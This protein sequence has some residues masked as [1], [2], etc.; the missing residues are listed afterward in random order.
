MIYVLSYPTFKE[1]LGRIESHKLN[2]FDAQDMC[3]IC[4]NDTIVP[5]FE[6]DHP[7]FKTDF[8][9]VLQL[10][11]DDVTEDC[12]VPIMGRDTTHTVKAMTTEQ[13]YNIINF[14][15][16][17]IEIGK[18]KNVLIHCR[19][20]ISRSGAVGS[21]LTNLLNIPYT[22]FKR[23]NPQILPNPHVLSTLN[24]LYRSNNFNN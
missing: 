4:I 23:Y 16:K 21:F 7:Y 15:S 18:T 5:G 6:S 10:Y 8:D 19:A 1:T 14:V 3:V 17:M 12:E 13:A 9:N 2:N 11:F 20:G 24:R 22:E